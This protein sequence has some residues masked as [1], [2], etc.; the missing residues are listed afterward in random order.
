VTPSIPLNAGQSIAVTLPTL[1]GGLTVIAPN[2]TTLTPANP[3]LSYTVSQAAGCVGVTNGGTP[4][5]QFLANGTGDATLTT[6]TTLAN[7][8]SGLSVSNAVIALNCVYSGGSYTPGVAQNVAVTSTATGGTPFTVVTTNLPAVSGTAAVSVT[9]TTGGTAGSTAMNYS[10]QAV[11]GCGGA[12]L[13]STTSGTLVLHDT[14]GPDKVISVSMQVTGATPLAATPN[15]ASFSYVKGSG[16]PSTLPIAVSS[17]SSPAPFFTVDT[18][19]LPI[20]L[21]VDAVSG[22]VP[23][24]L[25]FS[26]T[27]VCDS[28]APGTYTATVR[29]NVSNAGALSVQISLLITNSAPKLSV[30][31]STAVSLTWTMGQS[32]PTSYITLFSTDSPIPYSLVGGGPLAPS[33]TADL[34]TGLAY[35]FG[36]EIPVNFSSTVF[37]A[38]Q[39]AS[40]LTGTVTIT[41][42]NPASTTVVTFSITVLSPQ[43]TISSITPASLPT[44]TTPGQTFSLVLTGTG[45]VQSS[46]LSQKT[47]VG[48]V[49]G[50]SIV[51]DTNIASTVTNSSNMILGIT[52]A[53]NDTLLN[54]ATGGTVVL[55]VCNPQGATC[56]TPSSTVTLSISA[57][58]VIQ[59]VTSASSFQQVNAGQ[60]PNVAP[61]DM[62]SVFGTNF[63]ATG[64]PACA[65]TDVIPGALNAAT[66]V[67]Q[68]WV[69]KDAAG[70]TQRQ[71]TVEF[72][73]HGQTT[74]C[75]NAPLLFATNNQVNLLVPGSL[76]V[77]NQYDIIVSYGYGTTTNL[78]SSSPFTV[79]VI[80][81]DPGIFAVGADGQGSGAILNTSWALV[82][83]TNPAGMRSTATD[84]DIVQVYMTGLGVPTSTTGCM[85]PAAYATALSA[86]SNVS[87]PTADGAIIQ[88][89]LLPSNTHPPCLTTLPTVSIGGVATPPVTYAGWVADSVAGLYQVNVQLPGSGAGPFVDVNG[90]SHGAITAPVQL[91]I[92]ITANSVTSQTGVSIWVAPRL[93][94]TAPGTTTGQVGVVWSST[95]NSVTATEGTAPYHFAVTSGVLP[96]GLA[97]NASTGAITGTPVAGVAGSYVLT[98][99][100][101]DSAYVP[102]TGSVTFTLV[103]S[104]GLTLTA[105]TPSTTTVVATSTSLLTVAAAGGLNPYQ[106]SFDSNF[107]A[108]AGMT[109][110]LYTGVI[111]I[112]S[113]TPAG[114][115]NVK[116]DAQDANLWTGSISFTVTLHLAVS[117]T[118]GSAGLT[119]TSPNFTGLSTGTPYT[120]NL[121][122]TGGSSYTFSTPTQ[123]GFS[124]TGSVLTITAAEQASAY[125]VDINV[126]DGSGNT[127][128]LTLSITLQPVT[129]SIVAT[130]G[131]NLSGS[132]TSFYGTDGGGPYTITLA[133]TGGPSPT[134]SIT[135]Q[136]GGGSFTLNT[137]TLSLGVTS[138]GT[139]TVTVR[140]SDAGNTASTTLTVVLTDPVVESATAG[141]NVTLTSGTTFGGT[142][143]S[144]TFVVNLSATGGTNAGWTYAIT[145]QDASNSFGI[146]SNVLTLTTTTAGTYWATVSATDGNG[147]TNSITVTI[148]LQ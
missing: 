35:S 138:L 51:Q 74:G 40:V 112:T 116:V 119:G 105:G 120:I 91:P 66:L 76:T 141:T 103:V 89:A 136:T 83:S 94:V 99:T 128:T 18:T 17:S 148:V 19:S 115:Y 61:Y 123:A 142:A 6:T 25:H 63:C 146:S 140:S 147:N 43:A 21:S 102:V 5:I 129:L 23:K 65:S 114:T 96:T 12:L 100:A 71:L 24:T 14:P 127:G 7:S 118:S 130:A 67:Y 37:A 56:T 85:T 92:T 139:Y 50:N 125:S 8:V 30:S 22:T 38:A 95:T 126:T 104:G 133:T 60:T 68:T 84:S 135:S 106:Y 58:P 11:P 111:S 39:P 143:T 82:N 4:S 64:T 97:L 109:I 53:T 81:T 144:G 72:C 124:V 107:T 134:Y 29:L 75:V 28:L 52:V 117:A 57:G 54:F 1:T 9:P 42:G 34:A 79:N 108:P 13:G 41:W 16:T 87:V 33:V 20:W 10:L 15:P 121:A 73:P 46:D 32:V 69:A 113:A 132:G 31:P 59:E 88:S 80:A 137:G 93:L 145:S 90:L 86:A 3:S 62:V 70:P 122:A 47:K 77:S 131:S 27:S 26:S 98:V 44:S 48:V 36:T 2:V 101:T 49:T 55:G 78:F 110:N 45:F